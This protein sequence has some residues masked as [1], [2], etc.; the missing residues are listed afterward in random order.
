M[1]CQTLTDCFFS[2]TSFGMRSGGGVGDALWQRFIS[3][4]FYSFRYIF[5]FS[6]FM[7]I[8]IILMNIFFGIIID[9]FA[10]KR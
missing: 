10:D 5:D 4:E 8:N 3:D 7:I 6:F 2:T 1:N 9:S